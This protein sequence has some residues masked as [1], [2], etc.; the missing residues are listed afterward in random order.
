M[1][2]ELRINIETDVPIL[3]KCSLLRA[4]LSYDTPQKYQVVIP[5]Y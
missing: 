1:V 4:L 2:V 5:T 3:E